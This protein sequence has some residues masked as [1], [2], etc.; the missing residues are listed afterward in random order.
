MAGCVRRAVLAAGIIACVALQTASGG[1]VISGELKQWHKVTVTLDGPSA[2]ELDNAPNPFIDHRMTVTFKHE[3]GAP[4][5]VVPGYFAADGNAGETS[6]D[7]GTKWRAHLS[8]DKTGKWTWRVSFAT[9]RGAALDM[10]AAAKPIARFNGKSGS[11][12]IAATDKSGRDFRGRG[13]LQYVGKHYLQFAGSKEYFLK[14]GPDAPETFL[15]CKDFD[16]TRTKKVALKTWKPHVRDYRK[17]DPTWKG[18]K[19]KGI[20]GAINYLAAK[21][22]TGFSFLT[23]NAG[24][25]GDNVWPMV[26][27]DDKLH[28]D[29][30]KL[31]QWQIVFD[32]AQSRG[33]YLHFK[34][35]ETENDDNRGRKS[36]AAL[37]NGD[38]GVERK[39]YLRELI[40]RFGYELALNWNLGEENTQSLAQQR[41]MSG[42]IHDT[43]PYDH[44]I[45][46]H[47]Y[48][49]A[50][51]KVYR[52]LLGKG[53]LLTGASLQNGWNASH[54]RTL[55][56]VT[57][58]ARAGKPWVVANDEQNSAS[59]GVPPD[60]GYKGFDP[61]KGVKSPSIDDIRKHT[62]W[63][64]LMAGGAG[65]EYYFGY[66]L[67]QNDLLCEDYRSRDKSWDY[68]RIAIEFFDA[69]KIPFWEMKN[70]DA[71]VGNAKA[72]NSKYCLAKSGTVYLVYLPKGGS[73]DLDLSGIGGTFSVLWYNPRGGGKLLP[74]SVSKIR[75]GSSV[76]IGRP[77]S[78]A[79]KDWLAVVRRP[80]R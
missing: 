80:S 53:S 79:D 47:T 15:A 69:N 63:G 24:G 64:N 45:V 26:A 35:Q 16:G 78:D 49:G 28:Y 66:K 17:G 71:L 12:S 3:S 10:K 37:D 46:V 77:P 4:V 48:P 44:H 14:A 42:Y 20:I 19:G 7:A 25:D 74:G 11:F 70:A 33:L 5:Y 57:E 51:D 27:R 50:Q 68:C 60:P 56:W 72:D 21:G 75:A 55:K 67:P 76:S 22:C 73:S 32:H 18:G 31:D 39:L 38:T 61:K 40:A 62:L 59:T 8:P 29:C 54:N 34:L 52:P 6:A 36:S 43:D 30:S 41:A 58:S 65:V 2:R 13:R 9:G 23:Y 1:A